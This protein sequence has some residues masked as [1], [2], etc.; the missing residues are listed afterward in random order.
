M[1]VEE[2]TT[3]FASEPEKQR[4]ELQRRYLDGINKKPQAHSILAIK[5]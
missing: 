1:D 4:F 5:H 2:V 3:N